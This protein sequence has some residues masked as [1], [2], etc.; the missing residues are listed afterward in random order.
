MD[1]KLNRF[2]KM[3]KVF[4]TLAIALLTAILANASSESWI[5]RTTVVNPQP[6][7]KVIRNYGEIQISQER[8]DYF[9]FGHNLEFYNEAEGIVSASPGIAFEYYDT[10]NS[11]YGKT[12]IVSM[13]YYFNEGVI[14]ANKLRVRA[15]KIVDSGETV[16]SGR[17]ESILRVKI[18]IYGVPDI[19]S[20]EELLIHYQQMAELMEFAV[21][22]YFLGHGA[23][24]RII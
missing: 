15:D 12:N 23:A 9:R 13:N 2:S 19:L 24:I 11:S 17:G 3:K 14:F 1:K 5:N 6:D 7:A 16:S 8:G 18:L 21:L 4:P 10:E 22:K 20:Q